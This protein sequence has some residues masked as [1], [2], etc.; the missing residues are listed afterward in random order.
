MKEKSNFFS[1]II[2]RRIPQIIGMYIA[3]VWVAVEI[4]D[5]MSERFAVSDS[6]SSYVFVGLLSIL[7]SVILLA[8]GHGRP[9]KDRWAKKEIIWLPLNLILAFFVVNNLV[10]PSSDENTSEL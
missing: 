9:G 7:P 5:W 8:W 10:V 2:I 6:F 4:A 1:E 3:A